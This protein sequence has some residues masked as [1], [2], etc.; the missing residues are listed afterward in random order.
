MKQL[1]YVLFLLIL[2]MQISAQQLPQ[3]SLKH[4]NVFILNPAAAGQS[5]NNVIN[6]VHR[7][8]WVGFDNAPSTS[9]ISYNQKIG[10][11]SGVGGFLIS[12]RTFPTSRLIVNLSYAYRIDM[13]DLSLSF[14]LSGLIMQYRFKNSDLTYKDILDPSLELRSEQK[15]RP[16]ASFGLMLQSKSFYLQFAINQLLQS[17]F[18]SFAV[19]DEG[20]IKN[21]RLFCFSGQY[22]FF[23]DAHNFSPGIFIKYT[24]SSPVESDV[25]IEYNYNEKVFGSIAYRWADALNFSVGYKFNRFKLA[26]SFDIITSSLKISTAS[27]HEIML[28]IDISKHSDASAPSLY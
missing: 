17:N 21:S 26:Y 6:I 19:T 27:S 18:T 24:P 12:D 9:L 4:Q 14:G 5:D 7:E 22:H 20:L 3:L 16:E 2:S 25:S 8:Q 1:V 15:W 23:M 11:S 13:N 10:L 28:S